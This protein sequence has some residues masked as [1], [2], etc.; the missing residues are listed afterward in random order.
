MAG[1]KVLIVYAHQE[2]RSL[3]GSLKDV[4][5]A[6][7]SQQGCTV[8]VSDLYAMNFEPRA[9]GK[10]ITGTLSNP[11]FFNYGV[12]TH[13]AYEKRSLSSDIIEE[14][15]K[16]QEAD[17]VIFQFPL[18]WFSVPAVLKGW[19]DRVLCQGFA[20]DFPGSYDDGFL[21]GKLAILSLT[22]GGTASM[23]SKTGVNGDFRY[24]LWPLQH[25][26][27]HFCG[28]KVLAP[29]I[30]FSPEMASKEERKRM[31]ASWAQR[32]KTVWEEEPI[33]CSPPWYFGQ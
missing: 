17:L 32:L 30:S 15:K 11:G 24:F 12:E 25:G 16:L 28:F 14:Q 23:F 1:K 6:E 13:K 10:D 5:V 8:T 22:T 20:F 27:L 2:P 4:A 3:N 18:Y 19:M 7:L 33:P 9:T 21:K 26:T 31:V 29:Q